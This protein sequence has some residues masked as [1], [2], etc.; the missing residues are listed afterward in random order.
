MKITYYYYMAG[1]L[2]GAIILK[3][4]FIVDF[5]GYLLISLPL[6]IFVYRL[7]EVVTQKKIQK[8]SRLQDDGVRE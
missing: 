7:L 5:W 4:S 1:L 3:I 2:T 6:G 8:G